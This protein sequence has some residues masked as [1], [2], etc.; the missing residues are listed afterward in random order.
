MCITAN[1]PTAWCGTG[2]CGISIEGV[3]TG[4]WADCKPFGVRA[5]LEA[6]LKKNSVEECATTEM[7]PLELEALRAS[8]VNAQR[9]SEDDVTTQKKFNYNSGLPG[10]NRS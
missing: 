4:Y 9:C 6:V 8:S 7:P 5:E 10:K 1:W 2:D 3:S